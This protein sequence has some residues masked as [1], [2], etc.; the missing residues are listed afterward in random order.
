MDVGGQ[1]G[2]DGV[3]AGRELCSCAAV[4]RTA[5]QGRAPRVSS[6]GWS[7]RTSLGGGPSPKITPRERSLKPGL[8]KPPIDVAT[9]R[10]FPHLRPIFEEL[11]NHSPV[12]PAN[13][14]AQPFS[15]QR[16]ELPPASHGPQLRD[17][18]GG[19]SQRQPVREGTR[20]K[21][22][23]EQ[24]MSTHEP[25]AAAVMMTSADPVFLEETSRK[26]VRNRTFRHT[27]LSVG[28]REG[29]EHSCSTLWSRN[30]QY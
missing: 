3:R 5:V 20:D 2:L 8:A 9:Q 23:N 24:P 16:H 22:R 11:A 10:S 7:R 6:F 13:S 25:R 29:K 26:S 12:S 17:I 4:R 19:T 21:G 18:S 28:G 1:D 15:A 14:C 30:C 27:V